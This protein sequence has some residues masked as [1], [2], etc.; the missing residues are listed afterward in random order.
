MWHMY[1]YVY[2]KVY[3]YLVYVSYFPR[4][5]SRSSFRIC[6]FQKSLLRDK[7]FTISRD[8]IENMIPELFPETPRAPAL[9]FQSL[10]MFLFSGM[11]T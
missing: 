5:Q 4:L 6:V 2:V 1:V 8:S 7:V 3:V 11:D 9:I 10:Y